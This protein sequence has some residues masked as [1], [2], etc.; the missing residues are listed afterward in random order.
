MVETYLPRICV[1][2]SLL[3][4][5]VPSRQGREHVGTL[6]HESHQHR[7][8]AQ[9]GRSWSNRRRCPRRK[10]LLRSDHTGKDY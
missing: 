8:D 2:R 9:W 4:S 1:K 7:I 5:G 10:L 3:G 6:L